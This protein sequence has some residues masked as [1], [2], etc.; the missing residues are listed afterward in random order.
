MPL[1]TRKSRSKGGADAAAA[2][3]VSAVVAGVA[4]GYLSKPDSITS[5]LVHCSA[6]EPSTC[7]QPLRAPIGPCH[8]HIE[9]HECQTNEAKTSREGMVR[10]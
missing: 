8:A 10:W 3:G 9:C 1:L 7:I 6:E 5:K 2:E 4:A